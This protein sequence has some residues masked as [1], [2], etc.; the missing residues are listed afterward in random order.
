MKILTWNL[1]GGKKLQAI[2]DIIHYITNFRPDILF[3]LETM[4]SNVSSKLAT[5]GLRFQK[6]SNHR[7]FES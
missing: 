6:N 2:G 7:S 4:T 1:Q 3:V 5:K